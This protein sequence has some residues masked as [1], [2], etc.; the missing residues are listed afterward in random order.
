M[1]L[2]RWGEFCCVGALPRT[3]PT[4]DGFCSFRGQVG[5]LRGDWE[6]VKLG[7]W[8]IENDGT[9][10]SEIVGPTERNQLELKLRPFFNKFFY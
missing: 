10:G 5:A 7:G 9:R 4:T 8:C 1:L 6:C 2:P 3:V